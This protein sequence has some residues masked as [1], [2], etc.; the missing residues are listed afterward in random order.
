M[1]INHEITSKTIL[2]TGTS[3]G[4]GKHLASVYLDMGYK[5][6]GVSRSHTEINNPNFQSIQLDISDLTQIPTLKNILS[7]H[8]LVGLIN[9]SGIHGP[10]GALESTSMDQW[11]ETFNVNLF[12]HT[13]LT[14][15]CIPSLRANK[16]FIIFMSGGGSAFPRPNFSAYSVSKTGIVRLSEILAEELSPD[17]LV[18]CV[19]PGPNRT[20]LLTEAIKNG[21]IVSEDD[22]VDFGYVSRLCSFLGRNTNPRYSGKFIHV[23][24]NYM[25]WG[26]SDLAGDGYT[27]RRIKIV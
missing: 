9:N 14:Q 26:E 11:I 15:I 1:S 7:S 22:I 6:I 8:E 16:G 27:L 3:R 24:D 23:K 5:V 4:I 13:L 18:Y 20:D 25:E 19:A 2:I 21:E 12:G 10:I 17:I